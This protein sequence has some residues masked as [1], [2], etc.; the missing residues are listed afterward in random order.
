MKKLAIFDLD[1]TL[2]NTITDLGMATNYA[3]GKNGFPSHLITSYPNFVGNGVRK[4]IER[5]LPS[6]ATDSDTIDRL[7]ID[8]KEYYDGHNTDYTEIY[9]GI[10]NLIEGLNLLG[11]RIAVASNKYQSATE[12]IIKHYFPNLE[13]AAI[14]GQREGIPV[15]P[16]P[17]IVFSILEKANVIKQDAIFIGDSGVD[18]ETARRACVDSIGVTWGFRGE[19]E[20][21]R[22]YAMYVVDKPENILE[23]IKSNGIYTRYM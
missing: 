5:T 1:G 19:N 12:K 3:L 20:L 9:P 10:I 8:F 15:K 11:V 16:D 23:I 4:L 14:E 7:L 2:L 18:M 17:S 13:F 6:D 22:A 21:R